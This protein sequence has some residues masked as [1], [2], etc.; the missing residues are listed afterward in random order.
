MIYLKRIWLKIT[1][2]TCRLCG[3]WER[4]VTATK[5]YQNP[6]NLYDLCASVVNF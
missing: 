6:A 2:E 1:P 4:F 5:G 3:Q